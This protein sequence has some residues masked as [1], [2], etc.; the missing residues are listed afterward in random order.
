MMGNL[1]SENLFLQ[2]ADLSDYGDLLNDSFTI[3]SKALFSTIE[4][5]RICLFH[6]DDFPVL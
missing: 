1:R 3:F 6:F 4:G 5:F 2:L